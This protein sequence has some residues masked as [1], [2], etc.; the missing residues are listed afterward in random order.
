MSKKSARYDRFLRMLK[1]LRF[2]KCA[3][4]HYQLMREIVMPLMLKAKMNIQ[5]SRNISNP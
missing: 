1:F 3:D 4:K 5:G 2:L